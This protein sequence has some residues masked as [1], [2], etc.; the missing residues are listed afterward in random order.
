MQVLKEVGGD[1]TL[2][3]GGCTDTEDEAEKPNV[4]PC[5][6]SRPRAKTL[7]AIEIIKKTP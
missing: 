3:I 7:S 4:R 1:A 6:T 5:M 2:L